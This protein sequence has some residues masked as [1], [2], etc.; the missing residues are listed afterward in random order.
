MANPLPR[1]YYQYLGELQSVDFVLVE[2]TLYLDTHPDDAQA[3]AQF[4][5]FQRRKMALMS[6]IENAYGPLREYGNSPAGNH[7]SWADSPWP[8]Q[9]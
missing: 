2:L 5:Q 7:W 9:V 3:I 1:E 8:W 4:G 6:Q